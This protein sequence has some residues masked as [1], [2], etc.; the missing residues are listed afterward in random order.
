MH[1]V[2]TGGVKEG[3]TSGPLVAPT[4]VT[5]GDDEGNLGK[6]PD[7]DQA[8]APLGQYAVLDPEGWLQAPA[9]QSY[10]ATPL[11]PLDTMMVTPTADSFN[12]S[13]T[14]GQR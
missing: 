3:I 9:G 12:A 13:G 14:H 4:A 1:A 11:S 10:P 5:Y 6:K 8:P 2:M 7:P